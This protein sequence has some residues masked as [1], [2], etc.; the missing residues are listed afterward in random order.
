MRVLDVL[1]LR[2][3]AQMWLAGRGERPAMQVSCMNV[4]TNKRSHVMAGLICLLAYK[5]NGRALFFERKYLALQHAQMA[6]FFMP[7]IPTIVDIHPGR[8]VVINTATST[9]LDLSCSDDH[10]I[11]S[12]YTISVSAP[13][14]IFGLTDRSCIGKKTGARTRNGRFCRQIRDIST[15]MCLNRLRM[16]SSLS[17]H[18]RV[19]PF[20]PIHTDEPKLTDWLVVEEVK[21]IAIPTVEMRPHALWNIF[22][23]GANTVMYGYSQNPWHPAHAV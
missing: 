20:D 12:W 22:K 11:F 19:V 2:R 4:P 23:A 18:V 16:E 7:R 13:T 10:S 9:V 14:E 8:Y 6:T 3:N 21:P 15:D 1:D 5:W 17:I